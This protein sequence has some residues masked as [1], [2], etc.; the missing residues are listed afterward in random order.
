VK[1]YHLL[2]DHS[3]KA[4][5]AWPVGMTLPI[6]GTATETKLL[7]K[8]VAVELFRISASPGDTDLRSF[9]GSELPS[10]A[11]LH[12]PAAIKPLVEQVKAGT[13]FA[14]SKLTGKAE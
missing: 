1:Q 5:A 13:A 14:L 11:F 3:V 12:Q 6:G 8:L 7:R 2:L 9:V 10:S 4:Q